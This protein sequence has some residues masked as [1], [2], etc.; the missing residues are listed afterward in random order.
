[1]RA[2]LMYIDDWLSSKHIH[3]M[4]AHEERGYLR[5]LLYAATEPD[6]GIP[7]DDQELASISMLG[8][9]WFE[10]TKEEAKRFRNQTSGE[11]LR[12]SFVAKDGRLFNPRLLKEFEYQKEVS[13]KRKAAGVAS[14]QSRRRPK[15]QN[16]HMFNTCSTHVEQTDEQN[17]R[18][19]V[20][21]SVSGS[22]SLSLEKS[23]QSKP[24]PV[25]DLSLVIETVSKN[26]FDRHP[27]RRRDRAPAQIESSLAMILMFRQHQTDAERISYLRGLDNRHKKRCQS[28]DWRENGAKFVNNLSK[29]LVPEDGLYDLDPPTEDTEPELSQSEKAQIQRY[30]MSGD[31]EIEYQQF[32]KGILRKKGQDLERRTATR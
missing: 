19:D 11:K 16:E 31:P 3:R 24:P 5:L 21:V 15:S 6:C 28:L 1:M 23:E 25:E 9:Q 18:N 7:D 20:C 2:F 22:P 30:S 12:Q 32:M 10:P 13:E 17:G 8:K 27:A 14:G 26:I 29:W 4:D